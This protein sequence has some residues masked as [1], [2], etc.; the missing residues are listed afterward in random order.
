MQN[1]PRLA[2]GYS[3]KG[4][5]KGCQLVPVLWGDI[6]SLVNFINAFDYFKKEEFKGIIA[7]FMMVATYINQ[8]N[9]NVVYD[10]GSVE[11]FL[12]R[13]KKRAEGK[14]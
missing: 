3:A 4:F 9:G 13:I 12:L 6:I 14:L 1:T 10:F 2:A 7:P 11:Q 8:F 5:D